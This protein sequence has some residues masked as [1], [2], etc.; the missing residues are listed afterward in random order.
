MASFFRF[1]NKQAI[2]DRKVSR[3][4]GALFENFMAS[5]VNLIVT[6][7]RLL[8]PL[9]RRQE[10]Q[11]VTIKSPIDGVKFSNTIQLSPNS[12]EMCSV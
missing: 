9:A 11:F 6:T 1:A 8:A 2:N 12:R 10:T 4:D 7:I 5:I 3:I